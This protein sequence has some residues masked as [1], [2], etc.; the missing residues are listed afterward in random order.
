MNPTPNQQKKSE[1]NTITFNIEQNKEVMRI[2]K[3]GSVYWL[4]NGEMV[5]AEID[6]DL[7]LAFQT[8]IESFVKP[9]TP[10]QQNKKCICQEDNKLTQAL[11]SVHFSQNTEPEGIYSKDNDGGFHWKDKNIQKDLTYH[12]RDGESLTPPPQNTE[13]WIERFNKECCIKLNTNDI[14]G[15]GVEVSY[16]K[17]INFIS[18]TLTE[19]RR[20]EYQFFLNILDGIDTADKQMRVIGGTKAIRHALMIRFAGYGISLSTPIE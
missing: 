4:K 13:D 15:L 11:C 10:S 12:G 17:T 3:D 18:H 1:E 8:V 9:S 7:A 19:A 2:N 16:L 20:E 14:E 5:K 6:T